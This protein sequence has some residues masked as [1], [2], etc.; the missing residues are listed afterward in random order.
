MDFTSFQPWYISVLESIYYYLESF[1]VFT[2]SCMFQSNVLIM[3]HCRDKDRRNLQ[4]FIEPARVDIQ[5]QPTIDIHIFSLI[6][7]DAR[8][9][10]DLF[11]ADLKPKFHIFTRL[12]LADFNLI[13]MCSTIE[14][15]NTRFLSFYY[16]QHKLLGFLVVWIQDSFR[17]CIGTQ[18]FS[19]YSIYVFYS[20]Y[21]HVLLNHV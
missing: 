1:R 2:G 13:F 4:M 11:E 18:L 7:S 15:S 10:A 12:P 21:F 17:A 16:S 9:K 19:T 3:E 6:D 20:V 8:E 14:L 5:S